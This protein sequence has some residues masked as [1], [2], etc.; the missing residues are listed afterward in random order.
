MKKVYALSAFLVTFSF[1][2]HASDGKLLY[3][4]G[5]ENPIELSPEISW[6]I[7]GRPISQAVVEHEPK[8]GNR[9]VRGNFNSDVIDPIAKI[10]GYANVH[11]D[12]DFKKVPE[13]SSW[14]SNSEEIYVSWWFKL[15]RCHWKGTDFKNDDP[16]KMSAK[17]AY[18]SMNQ[19][20]ETSYYLS[21][22]GGASGAGSIGVNLASWMTMWEEQYQKSTIWGANNQG[23][24]PDGKWHKLSFHINKK[25]DGKKYLRWWIDDNPMTSQSA[26]LDNEILLVDNYS[27][28]TLGFWHTKQSLIDESKT[29]SE[30]D[31]CNGWQIDEVQVWDGIPSRPLP[32]KDL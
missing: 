23:F 19:D 15:D 24:G 7:S 8:F 4:Q 25:S 17:F 21:A 28:D 30:G 12:I 11:F 18:L 6:Q 27:F 22:R 20:T 13:L 26:G 5:F 32:P 9:S 2:V 29:L 1:V 10:R 31:N 3:R 14:I 16:L